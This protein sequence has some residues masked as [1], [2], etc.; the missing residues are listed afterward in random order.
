M[1]LPEG[2]AKYKPMKIEFIDLEKF[3]DSLHQDQFTGF[4]EF[5]SEY[6][7]IVILY[8]EGLV[9]RTFCLEKAAPTLMT[10]DAALERCQSPSGEVRGIILPREVVD[11]ITRLLFCTPAYQNLSTA[12]TDF[13]T[14]LK[15][16][17]G[18][19]FTGF[20]EIG[21]QENVH[22]LSLENGGP[23]SAI[24]FSKGHFLKG[25][26]ALERI[27]RE[28]ETARASITI[29]PYE[30]IP[31]KET[32]LVLLTALLTTYRELK[33]PMLTQ[34]FWKKLSSCARDFEEVTIRDLEFS[35]ESLPRDLRKQEK[36]LISILKCQMNLLADEIGE[37]TA[38]SL[39]MKWLE[40]TKSPIKEVFGGVVP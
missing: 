26:E 4:C 39:Y 28:E 7:S 16:L 15:T 22:Y 11:F 19:E 2:V 1:F 40:D 27:F 30:E 18:E 32:Y 20:I 33:G 23:R 24:Y 3:L 37:D 12:F 13:K 35:L 9:E 29:Y 8:E 17:E 38:R 31:L 36:I 10:L 25:S 34:Q 5:K 6:W 21:I 14:L